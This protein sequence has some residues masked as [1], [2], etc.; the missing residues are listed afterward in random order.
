MLSACDTQ[1]FANG[2]SNVGRS[3]GAQR[4]LNVRHTG[5][6]TRSTKR[7]FLFNHKIQIG[8]DQ[9]SEFDTGSALLLGT[10]VTELLGSPRGG[11]GRIWPLCAAPGTIAT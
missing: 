7:L 8:Q 10:E 2:H 9:F 1:L 6:K 3:A 4:L 11:P 5:A